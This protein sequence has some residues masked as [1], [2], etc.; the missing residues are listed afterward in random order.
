MIVL[1]SCLY[2]SLYMSLSLSL[3]LCLSLSEVRAAIAAR[4][5]ADRRLGLSAAE[6]GH[7]IES[8][9]FNLQKACRDPVGGISLN[10]P[11]AY[12]SS[13]RGAPSSLT[14]HFQEQQGLQK[15]ESLFRRFQ[16]LEA[17]MASIEVADEAKGKRKAPA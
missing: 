4:E 14:F 9:A 17:A 6:L 1:C 16:A 7:A 13:L 11:V 8:V 10:G 15:D 2:K 12:T 5:A 3:C